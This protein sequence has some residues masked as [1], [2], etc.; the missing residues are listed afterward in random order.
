MS[1][2]TKGLLS[3]IEDSGKPTKNGNPTKKKGKG[4]E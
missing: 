3:Q 4:Y 1:K 2:I